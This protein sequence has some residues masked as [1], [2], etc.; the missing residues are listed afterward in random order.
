MHLMNTVSNLIDNAIKYSRETPDIVITTRNNKK[1]VILT[2]EDNG[3]GIPTEQ[4]PEMFHL[5]AQGER[6]I[7]R[8]EG[9]LG[10]G[11]TQASLNIRATGTSTGTAELS[12]E[13]RD[14]DWG[15]TKRAPGL[16]TRMSWVPAPRWRTELPSS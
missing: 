15:R 2:I 13:W 10:I 8:S 12:P 11:L 16:N 1:N 7:D 5:F 3:I 6:S 14:V 9:G 4:M